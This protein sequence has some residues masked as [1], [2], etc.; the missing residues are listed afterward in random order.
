MM[1]YD[2][3]VSDGTIAE[4]VFSNIAEPRKT[5]DLAG[6]VTD[7]MFEDIPA[8]VAAATKRLILDEIVVTAAAMDTPMA[9]ALLRLKADRGGKA[10][11]TLIAD[12]RKVPAASAAYIHAQLAN[13]LDADET[14]H[15]RM[16]T[17]SANVM[18]G[19]AV[20]EMTNA[21]GRDLIASV[22]TG[23]DITSRIGVSL[24]QYVP[25]GKGGMIFAPLF[26][27]GWMSFGAAATTARLL[28]LDRRQLASAFGQA[29]VTTPVYFDVS[30]NNLR[31]LGEDRQASWHKYQMSGAMTEA[32]LNAAL[33]TS[34]GWVAQEDI[35]DEGSDFWK[36]FAVGGCDW[37]TMYN[38]LGKRWYI[39]ETSIKPYPFCRFGHAAL[40]IM[41]SIRD[42]H[43]L[44]A[45]DIEDVTVRI[46]PHELAEMLI[47]TPT[48]DEPLKL[49][50]S[51]PTAMA[52]VAL[53]VTP[54]PKWFSANYSDSKIHEFAG[55][56]RYE[57]NHGWGADLIGQMD[58]EGFFKRL[59]TE[60][61]VR[62]KN[63]TE[64]RE[65]RDYARGDPWSKETIYDD[66][67]IAEK[68]HQY[69]EG[70]ISKDTIDDLID[71]TINLEKSENILE[72]GKIFQK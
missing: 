7:T 38:D 31:L 66:A 42:R 49:M 23:Y 65:S 12:G 35:L 22:A 51:Q 67:Q 3:A 47:S 13:L 44:N 60:V 45:D 58:N 30:K 10:E 20:A 29:F 70:I 36:S 40:D 63:G 26:G 50:V 34:Y 33:L 72:F 68:A 4:S 5:S 43:S 53:G 32:G 1:T 69:L 6:F 48:A 15:N 62:T 39:T 14:M 16:H 2:E 24:T 41:T 56:V 59:P 64:L 46:V 19:L 18:A 9:R 28:G 8:D 25:D 17:L 11:A 57:T 27:W 21:S 52:L 71:M 37:D 55:K 54:G 61:I